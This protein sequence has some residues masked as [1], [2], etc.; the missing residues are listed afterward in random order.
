ML[1]QGCRFVARATALT[2]V[3]GGGYIGC[4]GLRD[5]EWTQAVAGTTALIL[6]VLV[7]S[8]LLIRYWL[9]RHSV[10]MRKDLESLATE[11]RALEDTARLVERQTAVNQLRINGVQKRLDQTLDEL[12][13]ERGKSLMLQRELRDLTEEHNLLIQETLQAGADRFAQ[14]GKARGNAQ[15]PTRHRATA[16]RGDHD[17]V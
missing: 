4:T 16:A 9:A 5:H 17:R 3:L 6:G 12:S 2:A 10:M 13:S 15:P 8:V 14:R 7:G 11:R 1:V